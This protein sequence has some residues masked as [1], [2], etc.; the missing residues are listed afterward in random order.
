MNIF[1]LIRTG[2]L[3]VQKRTFLTAAA[4]LLAGNLFAGDAGR[5]LYGC[6]ANV[7]G[8]L[9][10]GSASYYYA[11]TKMRDGVVRVASG[12]SHSLYIDGNGDL[13][14]CGTNSQGELGNGTTTASLEPV[15]IAHNVR[16]AVCGTQSTF[17]LT[18]DDELHACGYNY[19]GQLGT[20]DKTSRSSPVLVASNV[21]SIAAGDHY[22]LVLDRNG[23]LSGV[24]RN[25]S[26]Q[27]GNKDDLNDLTLWQTIATN[28][29]KIDAG[30]DTTLYLRSDGTLFGLGYNTY[31][32]LGVETTYTWTADR[33]QIATNVR[34]FCASGQAVFFIDNKNDLYGIGYNNGNYWGVGD[35]VV[36]TTTP[37]LIMG[38]VLKVA[39]GPGSSHILVITKDHRLH[40]IGNN[41]DYQLGRTGGTTFDTWQD[42]DTNVVDACA[43]WNRSLY[44]KATGLSCYPPRAEKGPKFAAV[45]WVDDTYFPW[46]WS[47]A[48][49]TWYYVYDGIC[50]DTAEGCWIFY[51]TS[52]F[53][54]Y[55][56]GYLYPETGWWCFKSDGSANWLYYGD[57]LP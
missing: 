56:W 9:C 33:I 21:D 6:G 29:T 15:F 13:Y 53:S 41:S 37:V 57:P 7:H 11:N 34:D 32:Q 24:G 12:Y 52:D 1:Q 49:G 47:Y 31:G 28:V 20:G 18:S 46:V 16:D 8:E 39:S 55:G 19:S 14:A 51:Y 42:V 30:N 38:D 23:V 44:I 17:Y 10:D 36:F 22:L 25:Q 3:P 54:D 35:S 48:L 40:S 26:G 45:G 4:T 27:L 43:V 2:T 5:A 50:A